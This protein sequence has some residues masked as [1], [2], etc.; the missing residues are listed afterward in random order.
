MAAEQW[1]HFSYFYG[2]INKG[3][4]GLKEGRL[5][6]SKP[7]FPRDPF[8]PDK[9]HLQKIPNCATRERPVVQIYEPTVNITQSNQ[10]IKCICLNF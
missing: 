7:H 9:L 3:D 8:P 10:I 1:G 2:I 6:T 5:S 4:S